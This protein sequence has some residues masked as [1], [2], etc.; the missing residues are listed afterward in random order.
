MVMIY[1]WLQVNFD[2]NVKRTGSETNFVY[3]LSFF[4]KLKLIILFSHF[5]LL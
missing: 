1:K 5:G 2:V 3:S 4:K